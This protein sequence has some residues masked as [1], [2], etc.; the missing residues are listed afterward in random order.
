MAAK[1]KAALTAFGQGPN[2]EEAVSGNAD[3]A[4]WG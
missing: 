3:T 1:A 2:S 4:S